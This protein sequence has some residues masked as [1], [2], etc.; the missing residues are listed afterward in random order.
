MRVAPEGLPQDGRQ[1]S[2]PFRDGGRVETA[3]RTHRPSGAGVGDRNGDEDRARP[4]RDASPVEATASE[5]HG[6]P[7]VAPG[8]NDRWVAAPPVET[9]GRRWKRDRDQRFGLPY[10]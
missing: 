2:D 10:R 5:A 1:Q 7:A 8:T 6:P 3:A 9:R 4:R